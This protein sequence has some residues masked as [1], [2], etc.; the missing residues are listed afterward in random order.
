MHWTGLGRGRWDTCDMYC[1]GLAGLGHE[2][3]GVG[4][5]LEHLSQLHSVPPPANPALPSN[6]QKPHCREGTAACGS[7][8]CLGGNGVM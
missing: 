5:L 2:G 6:T 1:L 7:Q 3:C 8:G 4:N